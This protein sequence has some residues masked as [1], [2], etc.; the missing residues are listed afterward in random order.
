MVHYIPKGFHN[1][2]SLMYSIFYFITN[3]DNLS[4]DILIFCVY[5]DL[6]CYFTSVND[7]KDKNSYHS[8]HLINVQVTVVFTY[9]DN[10]GVDIIISG[11][12]QNY[13]R[14]II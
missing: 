7:C 11:G 9:P 2:F 8:I 3:Y 14:V 12:R 5:N 13:P 6:I 1:T 10:V 4:T